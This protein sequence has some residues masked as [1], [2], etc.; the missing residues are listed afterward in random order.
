MELPGVP[1]AVLDDLKQRRWMPGCHGWL[2]WVVW[3]V[4]GCCTGVT[5]GPGLVCRIWTGL[6]R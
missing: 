4:I 5:V 3:F 1:I 6:W 2:W